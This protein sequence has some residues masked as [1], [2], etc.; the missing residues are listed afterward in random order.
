M[1]LKKRMK[2][3]LVPTDF[4][5]T[6]I[7]AAEYAIQMAKSINAQIILLHVFDIPVTVT[8]I[9]VVINTYDDFEKIK[10]QQLKDFQ[11]ELISK[12][13]SSI[14][15][16]SVLKAGFVND[17]ISEMVTE[18]EID[19]IVIGITGAGKASELLI[20]SNAS[21]VIKNSIC[22]IITIHENVKYTPIKKVAFACDYDE[23]E[24][25]PA[26][27]MLADFIEMFKAK[28]LIINIVDP[29]EK[30]TY[31]KI[32]S[33]ALLE[34]V[35]DKVNHTV[36]FQKNEDV[37]DG[38]NNFVD[39][40]KIDLLVMLPKKHTLFSRLFHES[41]SKKMAFHTHIPLLTIHH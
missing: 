2:N 34:H 38:I 14:S 28:L 25:S 4:S 10:E 11:N 13:G 32:L 22:P 21:R 36:S 9:P 17:V 16:T 40:H 31:K 24:E 41:N 30:P 1:Q 26:L 8:D 15:I 35:F 18:K 33:A 23:T 37:V 3:I 29:S 39:H 27:N 12:H 7:N 20:G 6:A 5:P 19:L